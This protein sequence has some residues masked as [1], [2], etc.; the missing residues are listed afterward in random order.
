MMMMMVMMT[1]N[2]DGN[3]EG[4]DVFDDIDNDIDDDNE[5]DV[6]VVDGVVVD[7]IV[8]RRVC[9]CVYVRVRV[10]ESTPL[11]KISGLVRKKLKPWVPIC[12]MCLGRVQLTDSHGY[13]GHMCHT[14]IVHPDD[15]IILT[16]QHAT[17]YVRKSWW[18]VSN[19]KSDFLY[20]AYV[21]YCDGI[22][23]FRAN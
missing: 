11:G 2:A 8:F 19:K 13:Y 1:M 5:G 6:V 4:D 7:L 15:D 21:T 12:G 17:E 18:K 14:Y 20:I 10:Q 23:V 9:V 3:D 22:R 16:R